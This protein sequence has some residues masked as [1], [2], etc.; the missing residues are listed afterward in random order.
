MTMWRQAWREYCRFTIKDGGRLLRPR[1]SSQILGAGWECHKEN[2]GGSV[3]HIVVEEREN[4]CEYRP[5]ICVCSKWNVQKR[6]V[7]KR[8]N[9]QRVLELDVVLILVSHGIDLRAFI[10]FFY[11]F[12]NFS[13]FFHPFLN[14]RPII[15][16][17]GW[18]LEGRK[19]E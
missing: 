3:V 14:L 16:G 15:V 9:T 12:F 17:S 18:N 7:E 2:N 4:V 10:G 5:I 6:N 13:F 19:V 8:N 11:L 1:W